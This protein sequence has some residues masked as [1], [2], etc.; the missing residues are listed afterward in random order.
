LRGGTRQRLP[1][2]AD[3]RRAA[4]FVAGGPMG[5]EGISAQGIFERI[6]KEESARPWGGAWRKRKSSNVWN[7]VKKKFQGLEVLERG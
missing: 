5:D 2:A 1:A 3:V 7:F 4:G 6:E